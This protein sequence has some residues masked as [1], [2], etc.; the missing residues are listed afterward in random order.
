[1]DLYLTQNSYYFV[2]KNFLRFFQKKNVE[3]IFVRESQKNIFIKLNELKNNFGLIDTIIIIIKELFWKIRLFYRVN[4]L[5][6]S[7]IN[8]EELNNILNYKLNSRKYKRLIS[9]GCPVK[10]NIDIVKNEKIT[11]I[12]LHGGITPFQVGKFSPLKGIKK[13]HKYLGSTI[14]HLSKFFDKGEIISQDYFIKEDCQKL[15][16]YNKVLC[17][18]SDILEDYLKNN[19]RVIPNSIKSYFLKLNNEKEIK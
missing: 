14:H 16:N 13:N 17:L 10:I 15:K 2:H 7:I 1:M 3:I 18:S 9:I 5:N 11:L 12:N 8:N 19:F 4:K 6:F